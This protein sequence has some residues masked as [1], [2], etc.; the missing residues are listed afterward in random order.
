VPCSRNA[1]SISS[2]SQMSDEV[3]R[4]FQVGACSIGLPIGRQLGRAQKPPGEHLYSTAKSF[5]ASLLGIIQFR[6]VDALNL[7]SVRVAAPGSLFFA[8]MARLVSTS[9]RRHFS[10]LWALVRPHHLPRVA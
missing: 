10:C 5:A 8:I 7:L 6:Y 3:N 9:V 1:P 4:K 2:A